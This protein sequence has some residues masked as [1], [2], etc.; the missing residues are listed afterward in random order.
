MVLFSNTSRNLMVFT[1]VRV[2]HPPFFA[3]AGSFVLLRGKRN[4]RCTRQQGE[5]RSSLATQPFVR[6]ARLFLAVLLNCDMYV[7]DSA[8][9][10]L[11]HAS[12]QTS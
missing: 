10:V 7:W 4:C 2:S 3:L 12:I 1:A 11:I 9:C 8:G 6:Q 5:Q